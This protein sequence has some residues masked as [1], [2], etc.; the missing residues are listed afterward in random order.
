MANNSISRATNGLSA[1]VYEDNVGLRQDEINKPQ[2]DTPKIFAQVTVIDGGVGD[3]NIVDLCQYPKEQAGT[4]REPQWRRLLV[5][6][7]FPKADGVVAGAILAALQKRALPVPRSAQNLVVPPLSQIQI[8]HFDQDHIGNAGPAIK[9]MKDEGLF[10]KW[11]QEERNEGRGYICEALYSQVPGA[12]PDLVAKFKSA[13][14]DSDTDISIIR[15]KFEIVGLRAWVEQLHEIGITPD[16]QFVLSDN[17]KGI[18]YHPSQQLNEFTVV[19]DWSADL[20]K[21]LLETVRDGDDNWY[22]TH[23]DSA[24]FKFGIGLYVQDQVNW[25]I[26]ENRGTDNSQEFTFKFNAWKVLSWTLYQWA[27]DSLEFQDLIIQEGFEDAFQE[28]YDMFIYRKDPPWRIDEPTQP[29]YKKYLAEMK[30]QLWYARAY[31]KATDPTIENKQ[32]WGVAEVAGTGPLGQ[33]GRL[34]RIVS[35]VTLAPPRKV[36]RD[37]SK[38]LV[39]EALGEGNKVGGRDIE[40]DIEEMVLNRASVVTSFVRADLGLKMLFT[41]DAYDQSCDL[42]NTIAGW[43]EIQNVYPITVDVLKIPHHGSNVTATSDFYEQVRAEVYL[44]CAS[45]TVHGNPKLSTLKTIIEGFS[46]KTRPSQLP[47]RIFFSDPDALVDYAKNKSAVKAITQY[48][49]YQPNNSLKYE[50]WKLRSGS[51][52]ENKPPNRAGNIYPKNTAWGSIVFYRDQQT[53]HLGETFDVT[54]WERCLPFP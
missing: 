39:A 43:N 5:D 18:I 21:K 25:K 44:V 36:V 34:D 31:F 24:N 20:I 50:M 37:L 45:H 46:G 48:A 10:E 28:L 26:N 1:V 27:E 9:L 16:F 11:T 38:Y 29:A 14:A 54:E 8:S 32:E 49:D 7:G 52:V 12:F 23:K 17:L 35:Q 42:Q 47:F 15:P 41:G 22:E 13:E 4:R 3:C 53:G 33:I 19:L 2:P 40:N 51:N 6:T 30:D